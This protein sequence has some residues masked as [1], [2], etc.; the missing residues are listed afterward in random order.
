MEVS[1]LRMQLL[2]VSERL[3]RVREVWREERP[4]TS[5]V[6]VQDRGRVRKLGRC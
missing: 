2:R 4:L 6:A 5:K 1:I 3:V